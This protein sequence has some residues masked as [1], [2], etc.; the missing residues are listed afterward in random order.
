MTANK[1]L[2]NLLG[3]VLVLGILVAGLALI[4]LPMYTQAQSI[5][6]MT[7]DSTQTNEVYQVR[8][9]QLTE[10]DARSGEIDANLA[11]L[12]T[13]IA[14]ETKYDDVI[15]IIAAAAQESDVVV[16]AITLTEPE[17]FLSRPRVIDSAGTGLPVEAETET[18]DSGTAPT[19]DS[20]GAGAEST[21]ETGTTGASSAGGDGV[22]VLGPQMRALITIDVTSESADAA[23]DF[24]DL[25]R[26]GPRLILP[27]NATFADSTLTLTAFTFIR[28]EDL[29]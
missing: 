20:D 7:Y 5:D 22:A 21:S 18:E 28:T 4:A 1:Q 8:V 10:A 6:S 11:A 15:E 19:D 14:S 12:R 25:L 26:V 13:E 9:A 3:I 24:V 27:V 16:D 2:V 29:P 23:M 17:A